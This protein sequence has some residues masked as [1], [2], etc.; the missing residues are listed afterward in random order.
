METPRF[1]SNTQASTVVGFYYRRDYAP[2]RSALSRRKTFFHD[3]AVCQPHA[4]VTPVQHDF[5]AGEVSR[6]LLEDLSG[7][8]GWMGY[9]GP[10]WLRNWERQGAIVIDTQY[11]FAPGYF[12]GRGKSKRCA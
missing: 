6:I 1:H 4:A 11:R 9:E 3:L 8:G 10:K 5:K 7:T 12:T 2:F